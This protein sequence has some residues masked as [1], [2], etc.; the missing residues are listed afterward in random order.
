MKYFVAFLALLVVVACSSKPTPVYQ[1][2]ELSPYERLSNFVKDRPGYVCA[3]KYSM[4]SQRL[5]RATHT[6]GP[7]KSGPFGIKTPHE[8]SYGYLA[9]EL[10]YV[11]TLFT[12]YLK[13]ALAKYIEEDS[14]WV[15]QD[16]CY[17]LTSSGINEAKQK[18]AEENALRLAKT[19]KEF[20]ERKCKEDFGFEEGTESYSNC[21]MKQSEIRQLEK[22]AEENK[23]TVINEEPKKSRKKSNYQ[24]CI[25]NYLGG[26]NCW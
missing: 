14:D 24:H 13:D 15:T 5:I 4:H 19:L 25:V 2:K 10:G 22:I 3:E 17:S 8:L 23:T 1:S 26:L 9:I 21:L 16:L 12:G 11:N 18:Q 7:Y 6:T 20:D